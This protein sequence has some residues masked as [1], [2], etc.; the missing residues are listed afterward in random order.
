MKI[1]D[2]VT[3]IIE[4]AKEEAI[5]LTA[6]L[7]LDGIVGSVVPGV[8]SA[9]FAY[10][11]KRQE[12]M[13]NL[14]LE[15]IEK[16]IIDIEKELSN[17]PKKRYNSIKDKYFGLISDYVL[18]EVQEEKIQYLTNGFINTI[19]MENINE[20]DILDYY[21]TINQLRL[22]DIIVLKIFAILY[23][24]EDE[25]NNNLDIYKSLDSDYSKNKAI[26]E[27]LER[28][29]L[30]ISKRDKRENDLYKNME[31]MQKVMKDIINGK[32]VSVNTSFKNLVTNDSYELSSYGKEFI[33]F[34]I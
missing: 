31:T 10:K 26:K 7:L 4:T 2:K 13:Y 8:M 32:K 33:K 24:D 11:Q 5:P 27:K 18:E 1:N 28:L 3:D 29:G 25:Y 9:V 15:N 20:N 21:D 16:R 14:W 23:I 34:F 22:I 12:R 6:E 17:I 19:K 30:L